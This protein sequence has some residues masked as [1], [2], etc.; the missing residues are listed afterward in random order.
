MCALC[1]QIAAMITTPF[2]VIKTHRQIELGEELVRHEGRKSTQSTW[3]LISQLYKDRGAS[4][5]YAGRV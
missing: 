1:Y 4:A 3:A 2:D 5:L